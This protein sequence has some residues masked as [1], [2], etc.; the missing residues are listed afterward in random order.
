MS[1]NSLDNL[2]E[3]VAV[4]I[5]ASGGVG[6]ATATRLAELGAQ[7]IGI[8]RTDVQRFQEQLNHL[9][10]NHLQ[11]LAIKAD[12]TDSK[13]LEAAV[14]LVN[15]CDI[16][17]NS[18]GYSKVILHG[19]L[20]ALTDELFDEIVSTNLR[21]VFSTI[22]S[23][24]PLLKKS[25][26][27]LIVNIGSASAIRT[28]GSNIAYAA[29]KAGIESITKNLAVALAPHIRVISICPSVLDTG[30]LDQPPAFYDRMSQ[31]TPLKRI[32]TPDDIA[33]AVGACATTLRFT[34]GNTFV[35]DGGK[36]L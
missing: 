32:G 29:A 36:T 6:F 23:F 34:T 19:N 14:K 33:Y 24:L 11:H 20:D 17:V 22:R 27:S 2:D 4:I 35:I 16:L 7:I 13:Q 26:E 31:A 12:I 15:Q 3:K 8:V 5:G 21:S 1:F 18:A 30:F 25:N 10:N 28:G 9:P